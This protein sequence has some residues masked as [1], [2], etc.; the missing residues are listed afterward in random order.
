M[1]FVTTATSSVRGFSWSIFVWCVTLA[2]E[3][4]VV[5]AVYW[6]G[7]AENLYLNLALVNVSN[8]L[9]ALGILY[10]LAKLFYFKTSFVEEDRIRWMCAG[11]DFWPPFPKWE[12]NSP[13]LLWNVCDY[14]KTTGWSQVYPSTDENGQKDDCNVQM[15]CDDSVGQLPPPIFDVQEGKATPLPM[16]HVTI[17]EQG[18]TVLPVTMTHYELSYL[19][20]VS[21]ND[22]PSLLV[23]VSYLLVKDCNRFLMESLHYFAKVHT[24]P[25]YVMTNAR[26]SES[27]QWIEE[28]LNHID[29]YLEMNRM[30]NVRIF[31]VQDSRSKAANL[32]AFIDLLPDA[33]SETAYKY[34]LSYDV[35]DRPMYNEHSLLAYAE[36]VVGTSR[37]GAVVA[38]IQGPCLECFNSTLS[39][40]MESH[41]EYIAQTGHLNFSN[42][43]MGYVRSQGSNHLI[44]TSAFRQY[45][46]NTQVLL[47][48]W[49]WSTDML[50]KGNLCLKFAS[51]MVCFGQTPKGWRALN[52]RRMRWTKGRLEETLYDA[53]LRGSR[54]GRMFTNWCAAWMNLCSLF[55]FTPVLHNLIVFG[56]SAIFEESRRHGRRGFLDPDQLEEGYAT[57]GHLW[58]ASWVC[59]L[60]CIFFPY[61]VHTVRSLVNPQSSCFLNGR[62]ELKY[63]VLHALIHVVDLVEPLYAPLTYHY[64]YYCN[65]EYLLEKLFFQKSDWTPTPKKVQAMDLKPDD[66]EAASQRELTEKS[67]SYLSLTTI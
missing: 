2:L 44:L 26:D 64:E 58:N 46:F 22:Q 49:R 32:N 9:T 60:F 6:T 51:T 38:G 19:S 56:F 59:V 39:G 30:D 25:I 37:A 61:S 15:G 66:T 63:K 28:Q 17:L 34:V 16:K 43:F 1:S 67:L 53:F 62:D 18:C 13:P 42:R 36:T 24:A 23:C 7:Q 29:R 4:W 54:C 50:E 35:D 40:L 57:L 8:I 21:K 52:R 33:N 41:T 14:S 65:V 5:F 20:N 48:D 47:E 10:V 11:D 3:L 45:R 27:S 31:F 55:I 12:W